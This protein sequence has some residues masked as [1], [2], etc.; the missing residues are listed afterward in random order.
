MPRDTH[1]TLNLMSNLLCA[2]RDFDAVVE[3]IR[4]A[5]ESGTE[6]TPEE[7]DKLAVDFSCVTARIHGCMALMA[8]P[9]PVAESPDPEASP[10][11]SPSES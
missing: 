6:F 8:V 2:R 3:P 11:T 4:E 5:I 7:L 9:A 10:S 1:A